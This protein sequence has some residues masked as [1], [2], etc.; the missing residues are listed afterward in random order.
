MKRCPEC[1]RD[2]FDDSLLYCLDDGSALLEGPASADEPHTAIL[3]ETAP[4]DAVTTRAH[5]YTTDQTAV[6]SSGVSEV[7]KVKAF[8]KRL[9]FAPLA[10]VIIAIAGFF[11]FRY[12]NA[13]GG[14]QINSIAVL[15]FENRSGNAD[16]DY[17][18]DGLAESLIYRLS[19]LPGLK[20]SPTSTVLTYKGSKSDVAT[21][22][23]EL[24][25]DAIM[26]GRLA[27][28]G[29]DLTI[30][31]ELIDAR[32]RKLIWA[33]QYDRKMADLLATQRE[34]ATTI[35]Q[36]LEL[37][38]SGNE[39][40][41][42]K[43]YTDNNEAYQL[44]MRGRYSFAK[45][46]KEEM[47]RSI[48]YFRQAVKL[49]PK[50]AL[51]Y[52]RMS[53]VYGSMPAYPYLSPKEAFPEAKAAAEKALEIDPTLSEAHTFLAYAQVIFDWDWEGG[54]RSFKR[55]LELDPNNFSA[56]FRYGQIYLL[57]VGRSDEAISEMD[58]GLKSEPLDVNMGISLAWAELVRGQNEKALAQVR[59]FYDLEPNHPLSQWVLAQVLLEMGK[60]EEA[61]SICE[62]WLQQD[63]NNQLALRDA[64]FASAKTGRRDKAEE[65]IARYR[66]IAKTQWIPTGRIAAIYGALGDKDKAFAELEKAFEAR[67]WDMH[68]LNVEVYMRPL[69]DDPRFASFVKRLN[70]PK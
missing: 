35:T 57:P 4:S 63:P 7:P 52:A 58:Q 14:D 32:T 48:D 31:V 16:T 61:I 18:S 30:S 34:I 21:I 51:A 43:K 27:Q 6:L 17:L 9:L 56:H 39:K 41:I 38:L 2:Y 13:A 68:R 1:R 8:D 15:P 60:Y 53:E 40:G 3:H 20:V 69:R 37:K 24:E 33:E 42:S 23:G 49:D 10:L 62:K 70:L 45:R 29:D 46:T 12:F 54:E 50:F 5:L 55:A 28:R 25:V 44:Y 22:A 64:G 59:R 67:D 47:L 26:S 19:Q 65:M 36:K 11:G 66:E